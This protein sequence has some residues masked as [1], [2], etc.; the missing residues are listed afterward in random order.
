[1]NGAD[2]TFTLDPQVPTVL[3]A[4]IAFGADVSRC[5]QSDRDRVLQSL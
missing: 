2:I 3:A 1:M 4:A 5:A